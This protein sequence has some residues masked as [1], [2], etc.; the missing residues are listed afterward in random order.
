MVAYQIARILTGIL[1][2]FSSRPQIWVFVGVPLCILGQG[3]MI[4]FTD[5][6]GGHV[7]NTSSL[8][9]SKVIV[10]VGRG[11]YH[12]ASQVSVQAVVSKQQLGVA[13]AVFLAWMTVGSAIGQR[14]V[15]SFD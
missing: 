2:R 8:V 12:T 5:M 7:A 6:S 1:L 15:L 9:A 13:T 10:G 11:L 4:Y 3:L 14:Q